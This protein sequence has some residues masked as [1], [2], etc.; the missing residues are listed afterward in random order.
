[1]HEIRD[2]VPQGFGREIANVALR[3]GIAEAS[4]AQL[5]VYDPDRQMDQVRDGKEVVESEPRRLAEDVVFPALA[6]CS[7]QQF[8]GREA[9]QAPHAGHS[10]SVQP[11]A[12][13]DRRAS[14]AA[15][16]PPNCCAPRTE[17]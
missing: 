12:R 6:D 3:A 17:R 2:K 15:C 8:G 5:Y 9:A 16:M 7:L 14:R 4:V 11:F 1:M 10:F 13:P